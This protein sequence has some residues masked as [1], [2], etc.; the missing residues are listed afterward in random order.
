LVTDITP[1]GTTTTIVTVGTT[2]SASFSGSVP[3]TYQWQQSVDN[4][5]WTLVAGATTT[6]L[7][8]YPQVP[9]T[10]YYR[11][12]ASN[13][14]NVAYSSSAELVATT[15]PSLPGTTLAVAGDLIVNLQAKD[16]VSGAPV[17]TNQ[18]ASTN[19]VGN[20]KALGGGNLNVLSSEAL[21]NDYH[22]VNV[23]NIN[24]IGNNAVQSTQLS[25]A[26]INGN[27]TVSMEVWVY[28][29]A[30][31]N[32]DT[33]VAYGVAGGSGAVQEERALE[34]GTQNY[35]AFTANYGNADLPWTTAPTVGWH[36]LAV[37]C[38]GTTVTLYQD[39]VAN[40]ADATPATPLN[41]LQTYVEVGSQNNSQAPAVVLTG[42][43]DPF[44]GY[45]SAARV[46]SGVLTGAQVLNNYNAG[47]FATVPA[48]LLPAPVL[49]ASFSGGKITLT[50]GPS[51]VLVQA[52]SLTGPWTPVPS[53][54]SPYQV[55]PTPGVKAMFYA[56]EQ[57]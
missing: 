39:G 14:V 28:A 6:S 5:T 56:V 47:L 40:G 21:A 33:A 24:G 46:E 44:N 38:D 1:A 10:N 8:V 34:Y 18:T 29:T 50:W 19:S 13:T 2:F 32:Q 35:G 3:L 11:L 27:G 25:P 31:G 22:N 57:P 30:L 23:L 41:T 52:S 43:A 4:T 45:I 37:T 7:T 51:A 9:G 36:Y 54:T 15:A 42:G 12:Q 48:S 20:F 55:T 26:E 17:W 53:A 16:L 49:G